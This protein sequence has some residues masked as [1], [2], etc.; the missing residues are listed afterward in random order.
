[1]SASAVNPATENRNDLLRAAAIFGDAE[2]AQAS[3]AAASDVNAKDVG[4]DAPLHFA[5]EWGY[6]EI[7]QALIAAGADVEAKANNGD[8]PL[9]Y[10][11]HFR[12]RTDAIRALVELGADVNAKF[13]D[14]TTLLHRMIFSGCA[15]DADM[16]RALVATGAE[17]DAKDKYGYTPLHFAAMYTQAEAFRALVEL[18]ANLRIRNGDERQTPL[19][20]A[21]D[22]ENA[23]L[24][25][26]LAEISRARRARLIAE[27]RA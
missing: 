11:T 25:D 6:A 15:A 20:L 23:A 3:I 12:A 26:A 14:G 17:I 9:L 24:D 27:T 5:A 2:T 1:M 16:I 22:M 13:G 7:A 8:T 4:G 21:S 18:G 10:A 19:E